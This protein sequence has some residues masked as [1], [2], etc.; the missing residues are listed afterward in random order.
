MT[1]KEL[2]KKL[3]KF[4]KNLDVAVAVNDEDGEEFTIEASD[5][6]IFFVIKREEE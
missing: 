1:V 5:L 2:I 4:D 6:C 3:S